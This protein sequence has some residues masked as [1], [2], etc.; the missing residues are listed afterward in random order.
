MFNSYH[1][2]SLTVSTGQEFGQWG[3]VDDLSLL[4]DIWDLSWKTQKL[5]G[6]L[7][8]KG[9]LGHTSAG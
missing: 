4:H 8:L 2:F 3:R 5:G 1:L 6:G 7:S 9:L